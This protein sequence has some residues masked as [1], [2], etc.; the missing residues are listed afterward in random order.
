VFEE[1]FSRSKALDNALLEVGNIITVA[2]YLGVIN[3]G[4]EK[5]ADNAIE[6]MATIIRIFLHLK[7]NEINPDELN[8]SLFL[9]VSVIA[10]L[11]IYLANLRKNQ[12][13]RH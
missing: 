10:I 13:G 3:S 2:L 9:T 5:K 1:G 11:K 6:I 7:I 4:D 12:K 8:S